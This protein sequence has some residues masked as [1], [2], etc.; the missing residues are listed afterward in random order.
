MWRRCGAMSRMSS[1]TPKETPC[2]IPCASG[3]N[4]FTDCLVGMHGDLFRIVGHSQMDFIREDALRLAD[5]IHEHLG[6][7]RPEPKP[8]VMTTAS[9]G[10]AIVDEAMAMLYSRSKLGQEKYGATL[11]RQD[12][13][14]VDWMRYAIEES[15]DR[16]LYLLRATKDLEKLYDDGR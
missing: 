9:S 4:V 15:L 12:L 1:Q 16:T 11:M 7:G 14:L 3:N 13:C 6:H 10:D 2:F 8:A 5:Y